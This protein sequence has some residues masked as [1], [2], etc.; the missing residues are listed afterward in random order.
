ML[1][2]HA[3]GWHS[4][5]SEGKHKSL[6]NIDRDGSFEGVKLRVALQR[7]TV[8]RMKFTDE[9]RM[10]MQCNVLHERSTISFQPFVDFSQMRTYVLLLIYS[11][12]IRWVVNEVTLKECSQKG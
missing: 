4:T 8:P 6:G 5:L 11:G 3:V 1:W 7:F 9:F 10:Q 2:M 12:R